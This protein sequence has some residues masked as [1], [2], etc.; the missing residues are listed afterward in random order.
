[1]GKEM[2]NTII[3]ILSIVAIILLVRSCESKE[4][5]IV[6]KTKTVT[7]IVHDTIK[8]IEISEPKKVYYWKR[9]RAEG[10]GNDARP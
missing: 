10:Y 6:T 9:K 8:S 3:I 2:K 4:P 5:K 1:M 7:K